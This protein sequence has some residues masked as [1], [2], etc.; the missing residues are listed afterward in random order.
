MIYENQL[1]PRHWLTVSLENRSANRLGIG[2]RVWVRTADRTQV[3]EVFPANTYRSQA[4]RRVHFGLGDSERVEAVTARWPN[5]DWQTW[6]NLAPN[7]HLR[8]TKGQS[9][10]VT[11]VPGRVVR[12][13]P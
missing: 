6:R 13:L 11:V 4:P 7:R 5:G 8:L 1:P 10:A 2:A 3:R 12:P 9:Q